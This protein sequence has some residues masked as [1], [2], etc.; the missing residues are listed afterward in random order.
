MAHLARLDSNEF[1]FTGGIRKP[2]GNNDLFYCCKEPKCKSQSH[3]PLSLW[4]VSLSLRIILISC[5]L[6]CQVQAG[7]HV[8]LPLDKLGDLSKHRERLVK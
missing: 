7:V 1:I 8:F 3:N 6:L 4:W 2:A 5:C